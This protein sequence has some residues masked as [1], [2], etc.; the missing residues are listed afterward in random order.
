VRCWTPPHHRWERWTLA[1][2]LLCHRTALYHATDFV[3]PLLPRSIGRVVTVHDLAFLDAPEELDPPAFRYYARTVASVRAADRVIAVSATTAARL[4]ALCP[5]VRDRV[6][7]I[8]HGVDR[9]WFQPVLDAWQRVERALG[10]GARRPLVLAVGT[11]EPRKGYDILLDAFWLVRQ[12]YSGE[13]LLVIVGQEGW[14]AGHVVQRIRE[15]EARGLVRW[16]EGADDGLLQALYTVSSVL[17]VASRDEGFCFPALEALAAGV[18]VVAFAVG[19]LPEI[20]GQ[21][22]V[23]VAERTAEALAAGISVVLSDDTRRQQLVR[24]GRARAEEFSWERAAR[25]TI[26]VYREALGD[27]G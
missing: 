13:P 22:G 3:L 1:S 5:E 15:E 25:E 20:L 14:K 10:T 9:R 23:L 11:V 4:V 12:W 17:V 24:A 7:V 27:G 2:E 26:R 6:R 18:P 21:A 19:A 8:Y 16:I